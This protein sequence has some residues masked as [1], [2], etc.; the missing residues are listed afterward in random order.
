MITKYRLLKKRKIFG[1]MRPVGTI[2]IDPGKGDELLKPYSHELLIVS[3]CIC[4]VSGKTDK[5]DMWIIGPT[6]IG[7]IKKRDLEEIND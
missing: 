3:P 4:C 2:L 6:K 5:E 1:I 7:M